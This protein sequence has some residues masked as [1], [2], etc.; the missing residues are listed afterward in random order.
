MSVR[1]TG[2]LGPNFLV[3][4]VFLK[5]PQSPPNMQKISI[6]ML[7]FHLNLHIQWYLFMIGPWIDGVRESDHWPKFLSLGFNIIWEIFSRWVLPGRA[8]ILKKNITPIPSTWHDNSTNS[9]NINC[10]LP[11]FFRFF[12]SKSL[13]QRLEVV[14]SCFLYEW[15]DEKYPSLPFEIA[16]KALQSAI[17][18]YVVVP[19]EKM[20][21]WKKTVWKSRMVGFNP[22]KS[23]ESP[24]KLR[25][26]NETSNSTNDDIHRFYEFSECKMNFEN[27]ELQHV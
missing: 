13:K 3:M 5:G 6:V 21:F 23:E 27:S 11:I 9:S 22:K 24:H 14:Q 16:P 17:P 10:F 2:F 15:S 20:A 7:K 12:I 1:T 19:R 4:W 8:V 26:S 25:E 18:R